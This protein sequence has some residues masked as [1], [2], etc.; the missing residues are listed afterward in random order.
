MEN[1]LQLKGYRHHK[2][3][4]LGVWIVP[5]INNNLQV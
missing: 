3:E 2:R 5:G 4:N 1:N